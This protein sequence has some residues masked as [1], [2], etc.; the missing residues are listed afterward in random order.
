MLSKLKVN[1]RLVGSS[2]LVF[3]L[4]GTL[5]LTSCLNT[6]DPEPLEIANVS[7]YHGSPD[8][9]GL[10][11]IVGSNQI[12]NNSFEFE[13]YSYYIDFFPGDRQLKF[14]EHDNLSNVLIDTTFT[15][16]IDKIYSVYIADSLSS[17]EAVLLNDEFPEAETGKAMVRFV[18]LSPDV[19]E[20]NVSI[21]EENLFNEQTFKDGTDFV[22]INAGTTTLGVVTANELNE[23][24]LNVPD[25]KFEEGNYYTIILNG[26]RTPPDGNTNELSADIIEL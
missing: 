25:V 26:F 14:T 22:G 5:F 24:L 20:I 17:I 2:L 13:D 18:H 6:D 7:I 11:I 12:N 15:F 19:Q 23:V 9:G 1:G 4:F 16:E 10:D 21:D 3:F 8:A